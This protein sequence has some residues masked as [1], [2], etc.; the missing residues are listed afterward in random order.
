MTNTP[1]GIAHQFGPAPLPV[2]VG[3]RATH[4]EVDAFVALPFEPTSCLRE[5]SGLSAKDLDRERNI[6][7]VGL[8]QLQ[9]FDSTSQ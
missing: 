1:I 5:I 9:R 7:T 4:V 2:D 3:H 6:L 8:D